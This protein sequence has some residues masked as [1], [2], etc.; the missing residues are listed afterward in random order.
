MS[1]SSAGPSS[2]ASVCHVSSG[3]CFPC[4][5]FSVAVPC[6]LFLLTFLEPAFDCFRFPLLLTGAAPVMDESAGLAV[7]STSVGGKE[8]EH[9]EL[10][11]FIAGEFQYL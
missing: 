8:D 5:V 4:P 10:L 7:G 11:L 9:D 3:G 6:F 1:A 2:I